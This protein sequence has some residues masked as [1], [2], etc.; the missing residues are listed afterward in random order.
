MSVDTATADS[1]GTKR[2]GSR[3]QR[4]FGASL[5][6]NIGDG[7]GT[8]AYPWLASAITRNP[9]LIAAVAV[10]QRLPWLVFSLPAG[11]ITDRVDRRRAIVAMDACRFAITAAV[12]LVVLGI[13]G[14][15]PAPDELDDVVGTRTGLYVLVLLATLL[16]GTCEVLRDNSAQTI[17]PSIVR[18]AQLERANGRL[19]AMELVANT[20]AGPPLG[21]LL[22]G[23]AFAL[24]I[25]VDAASFFVAA[26]LVFSIGGSFRADHGDDAPASWRADLREG[27]RWLRGHRVL[28]PM[29]II[30][31][32]LNLASMVSGGLLVLYAQEVLHTSSLT[33]ALLGFGIAIGGVVGGAAAS[34]LSQRFGAGTCL[35]ITLAGCT[36][37]PIINAFSVHWVMTAALLGLTSMIGVLWNV[38]TVSFRQSIIP[39]RLLGRINSAYR[40]FA[41]GMMP[42]GAALGGMLVAAVDLFAS[43]SLALRSTF[44]AE[45]VICAGLFVAGRHFLSTERIEAARAEAAAVS[46]G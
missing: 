25:L 40:F 2:L 11:V 37:F 3:F 31:G 30:L 6:T 28:F 46:T 7:M 34:Y 35:A 27:L 5:V 8:V 26:A 43:R 39:P 21:S 15:L 42:I 38:I 22:L 10:V 41:W 18:P 16:L 14:S 32:L 33:F 4:L 24:P 19:G 44:V 9:L 45:G 29:A 36:V 23:V 1:V 12:G 13:Q 20:F 17:L